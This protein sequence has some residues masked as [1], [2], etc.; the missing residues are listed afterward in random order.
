[1]LLL[2]AFPY[3][4]GAATGFIVGYLEAQARAER[5]RQRDAIPPLISTGW[6]RR[7]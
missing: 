3:L 7:L 6:R 2:V 4:V 5:K 1:L